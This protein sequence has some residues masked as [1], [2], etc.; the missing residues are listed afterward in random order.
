MTAFLITHLFKAKTKATDPDFRQFRSAIEQ[1]AT[2][3]ETNATVTLLR[4]GDVVLSVDDTTVGNAIIEDLKSLPSVTVS[5]I[6]NPLEAYVKGRLQKS[7][8]AK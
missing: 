3:Q 4:N 6:S 8:S 7:T 2:E 1:T 5:G